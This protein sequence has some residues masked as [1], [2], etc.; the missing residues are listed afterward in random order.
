MLQDLDFSQNMLKVGDRKSKSTYPQIE[1]IH[2]N[3]MELP[4]E[5]NTFDY[6]T[7]GFGLRNVPDYMQVLKEMNRVAKTRRNGCLFRNISTGIAEIIVNVFPFL[8]PLYY[9]FIW[10]I[11]C[12]KL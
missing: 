8:F 9:A 6:V 3:A 12:E 10:E 4:F 11:F 7:I 5:D 2:G 1:F